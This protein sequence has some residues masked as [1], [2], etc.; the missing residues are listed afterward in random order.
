M[1]LSTPAAA[2]VTAA[3]EPVAAA[4]A[5]GARQTA[6]AIE[7]KI[8]ALKAAEDAA[9]DKLAGIMKKIAAGAAAADL[10][11][12]AEAADKTYQDKKVSDPAIMAAKK[13]D[14]DAAAAF[15][16]AVLAKVKT[17]VQG[18]A[19][20]KEIADLEN[21]RAD[22]SVQAAVAELKLEH[23]DS[24]VSR[25]LGA[26]PVLKEYYRSYQSAPKGDKRTEARENYYKLKKEAL[27]R[28]PQAKTLMA[29]IATCEKS[30][31]EAEN[32]IEAA[33]D[34]LDELYDAAADSDDEDIAVAKAKRETA[35]KAHQQAYY[36]GEMQAARDAR[37]AAKKALSD[38]VKTLA[39]ANPQAVELKKTLD[40]LDEQ[41]DAL[42]AQAR[43]L[44]KNAEK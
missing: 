12:A 24:A 1:L 38:K 43:K 7:A 2:Q 31:E 42:R 19:I 17:S 41:I 22:L 34:K 25:V 11:K 8:K 21:K 36:G 23:K 5:A 44:R 15:K 20:L 39:A 14:K 13:A 26:D 9:E 33:E 37:T 28:L 16:A 4:P 3:P 29:E 18:A 35:R 32:A 30:I 27:A 10:K 40:A 6:E